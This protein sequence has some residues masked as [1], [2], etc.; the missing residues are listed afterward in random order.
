MRDGVLSWLIRTAKTSPA[1]HLFSD[2]IR[3]SALIIKNCV[4][5]RKDNQGIARI[6]LKTYYF[7]QLSQNVATSDIRR[8][9]VQPFLLRHL[10]ISWP[11]GAPW[12]YAATRAPLAALYDLL[13]IYIFI[14]FTF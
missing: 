6:S 3:S 10:D 14:Y 7:V 11:S 4:P 12:L 9:P 8:L 2:I 5:L 1:V 13:F